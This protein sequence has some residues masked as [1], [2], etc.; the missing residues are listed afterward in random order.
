MTQL[1]AALSSARTKSRNVSTLKA[2]LRTA[3]VERDDAIREAYATG[4][5]I[6]ELRRATGLTRAMLYR[7]VGAPNEHPGPQTP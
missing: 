7:I 4:E 3:T 6:A 2:E 1:S 5:T